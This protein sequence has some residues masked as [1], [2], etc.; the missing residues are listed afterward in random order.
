MKNNKKTS[1]ILNFDLDSIR[2]SI[3]KRA[4]RKQI[5]ILK[6]VGKLLDR[7]SFFQRLGIPFSKKEQKEVISVS[8]SILG[9]RYVYPE[10]QI[11]KD[12]KIYPWVK[13]LLKIIPN[14]LEALSFLTQNHPLY[15][16][17]SYVNVVLD[18]PSK[19]NSMLTAARKYSKD[20][21]KQNIIT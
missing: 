6:L 13:K 11:N 15:N 20:K 5:E 17:R 19:V 12:G 18:A 14:G 2:F 9:M 7:K 10:F 3:K 4:S 21:I 1:D 16:G 8:F